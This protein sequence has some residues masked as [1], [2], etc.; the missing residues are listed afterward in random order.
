[1]RFDVFLVECPLFILELEGPNPL[2][3]FEEVPEVLLHIILVGLRFL[4]LILLKGL[5]ITHP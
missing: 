4:G 3:L 5:D 2:L 1:M